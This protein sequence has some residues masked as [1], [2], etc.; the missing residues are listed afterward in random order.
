MGAGSGKGCAVPFPTIPPTTTTPPQ[1]LPPLPPLCLQVSFGPIAWL[2]VGEVFPLAARSRAAALATLTN[3]GANA[4]VSLALPT[5]QAAAGP[6]ATYAGFALV[7][8]A[9]AAVIA[10]TVPETKGKTLEEI[11]AMFA[12]EEERDGGE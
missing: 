7:A 12:A 1:T 2:I 10:A 11:E 5:L 6:A 3:F 4:A 9:S 8:A